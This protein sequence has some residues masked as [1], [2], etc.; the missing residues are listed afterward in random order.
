MKADDLDRMQTVG[1]NAYTDDEVVWCKETIRYLR[2]LLDY[3][4]L[5]DC[6]LPVSDLRRTSRRMVIQTFAATYKFLCSV[7]P[8]STSSSKKGRDPTALGT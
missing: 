6:G 7:T 4:G 2:G 1:E 8:A 5:I 3:Q